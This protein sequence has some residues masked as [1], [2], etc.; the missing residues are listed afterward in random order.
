MRLLLLWTYYDAYLEH[1][2]R[3][4]PA[5]GRASYEQQLKAILDDCFGWPP[6]VA[7][8]LAEQGHETRVVIANAEPLQRA[9]A[10][11]NGCEFHPSRWRHEIARLQVQRFSPSVLWLGSSPEY[12]GDFLDGPT[13]LAPRTFAWIA[14][15]LPA[16]FRLRH[17]DGILTS[18]DTLRQRFAEAG[19]DAQVVLPCFEPRILDA[20][21]EVERDVALSFTGSLSWAHAT[22]VEFMSRLAAQSPLQLWVARPRL[23]SRGWLEPGYLRLWLRGRKLAARSR[24]PVFGMEMYRVLAR[25]QATV[26][27]HIGIAGGLAGNMRM[28][29]ATGCGAALFTEDMPNLSDL[30]EPET[31]VVP[32]RSAED[33]VGRVRELLGQPERLRAIARAGQARTLRDHS[34]AVR[35]RQ[36]AGIFDSHLAGAAA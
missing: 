13:R 31:E 9:W 1:F 7:R 36:I 5:L 11:E 17:L 29:E 10:R 6:A 8:R 23:L 3:R 30:F 12:L 21:G 2:Y 15:P 16:G 18:H 27:V 26:N 32:Y 14:A 22:R 24:P 25:S 33:L 20:L 19:V 34:T 4:F 28:F 35:A